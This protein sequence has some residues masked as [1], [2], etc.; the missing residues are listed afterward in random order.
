MKY[1][2]VVVLFH[3]EDDLSDNIKSYI[4]ELDKLYIID[5]TP[6][7]DISEKFKNN[8][9]IEYI[10]LKENKGIAYALNLGAKKAIKDKTD[11]LLTMDQDSKFIDNALSRMKE[12]IELSKKNK[13]MELINNVKYSEIGLISPFHVTV[14]TG[15]EERFGI[16]SPLNVMTSGNLINLSAYKKVNGF[17]DWLFIDCVDFD[18]CLN[19]RKNGYQI[20]QLNF[21]KLQ[22][23]LGNTKKIM[24]GNKT[25]YV[26]NHSAFR[27]YYIARNRNYLYDLYNKDFPD[28]CKLE[29]KQTRKELIKIWIFEKNKIKKTK[30]IYRGYRDY[31][32]GIKGDGTYEQKK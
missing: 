9:K 28:Y 7:V 3:P 13:Y 27:R 25:I 19:L 8:K 32:K 31:K 12:F 29:L 1:E 14:R 30:A 18:Y 22:H 26:D 6:D 20:L 24:I 15:K 17:K 2:G 21:A 23:E 10:P 16:E 11:W 4:N 5:N